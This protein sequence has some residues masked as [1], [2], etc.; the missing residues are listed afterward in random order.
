VISGK[1]SMY[2]QATMYAEDGTKVKRGVFPEIQMITFSKIDDAKDIV[3]IDAKQK[4]DLVYIVGAKTKDDLGGSEYTN[5]YSEHEGIDN[6]VGNVS[7]ENVADVFDTFGK[8]NE[9]QKQKLLQ[10]AAYIEAGGLAAA[11]RNTAMAGEIGVEVNIEKVAAIREMH[12]NKSLF[13]ETEGRFLVTV[14]REDKD[15]LEKVFAGKHYRIGEVKGKDVV[16]KDSRTTLITENL[17]YMLRV[18]HGRAA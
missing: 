11:L 3:T 15:M 18:Y 12:Y 9:A 10:S 16:I 5:M 8:M 17:D 2:N 4:G 1:D 6:R 14:K 7:D 13:S